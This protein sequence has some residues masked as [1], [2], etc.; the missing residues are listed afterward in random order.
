MLA[1]FERLLD[2]FP[3]DLPARPPRSLFGFIWHYAQPV[4]PIS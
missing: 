3:A 4:W 2:S 1:Y